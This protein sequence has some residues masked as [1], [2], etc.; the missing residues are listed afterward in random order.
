MIPFEIAGVK[1]GTSA[2]RHRQ[3]GSS[4]I[5][6][7]ISNYE[8]ELRKHFVILSS[9]ERRKK[10]EAE[11]AALGAKPDADLLE[12]LTFIT[13][14]PTAIRGDFD[15]SFL[16]LPTEVLTTV[17]KHHQKTFSIESAPGVL[18]P[19]FVAIMNTSGDPDRSKLGA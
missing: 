3:L 16:A 11:S 13:E 6:V 1:A 9:D 8:S 2:R 15:P 10:I 7:T 19:H 18:A 17:L 4:S 12:T 5:P 14:Y